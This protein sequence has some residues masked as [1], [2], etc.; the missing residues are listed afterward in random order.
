[1]KKALPII[2]L[3]FLAIGI[4]CGQNHTKDE[5]ILLQAANAQKGKGFIGCL[6]PAAAFEIYETR[7][8]GG[9]SF[10]FNAMAG[11]FFAKRY[12]FCGSFSLDNYW[13]SDKNMIDKSCSI[14]VR[15][16]FLKRASL[17]LGLGCEL[18][19]YRQVDKAGTID[20]YGYIRPRIECGY[21]YLITELHPALD[22]HVG[23]EVSCSTMIPF[24]ND[25][26]MQIYVFPA[27]KFRFSILYHF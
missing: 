22:N 5:N 12:C 4:A 27:A 2:G 15:R 20:S 8:S 23:L 6:I 3:L 13:D 1:M 11:Y 18:G 14:G 7:L 21:E 26:N 9:Q 16:Y 19:H 17:F 10:D 25:N 24:A